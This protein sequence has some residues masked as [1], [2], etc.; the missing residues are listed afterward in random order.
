MS[1][2]KKSAGIALAVLLAGLAL[3]GCVPGGNNGATPTVSVAPSPTAAA[4]AKPIPAATPTQP[5]VTADSS[6]A[7]PESDAV[8]FSYFDDAVFIGIRFP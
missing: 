8:G 2:T 4:T 7:V 5:A 6:A 3:A 1:R